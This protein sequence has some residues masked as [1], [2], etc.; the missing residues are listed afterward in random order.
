MALVGGT[1][2]LGGTFT[3]IGGARTGSGAAIDA[4]TANTPAG[5]TPLGINGTVSATAPDGNGGWYVG[6]SFTRIGAVTRNNLAR[7]NGDGSLHPWNPS[8]SGGSVLA[9]AVSGSTAYVGGYFTAIG[10]VT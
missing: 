9:L 6:G 7:I 5:L 10:G 4:V 8:A 1:L 2:Y 3:V